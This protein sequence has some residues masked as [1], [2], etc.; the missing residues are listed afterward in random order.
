MSWLVAV[1]LQA[2][3]ALSVRLAQASVLAVDRSVVFD[4]LDL[5][6]RDLV[7][8]VVL[9]RLA[10]AGCLLLARSWQPLVQRA[11]LVVL[12]LAYFLDEQS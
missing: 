9:A 3:L 7:H 10:W 2:C 4:W 5:T 6:V 12:V 11:R 1:G 8:W